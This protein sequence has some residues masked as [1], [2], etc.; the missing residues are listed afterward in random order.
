MQNPFLSIGM[1]IRF[2]MVAYFDEN[3]PQSGV[4]S[5]QGSSAVIETYS[6]FNSKRAQQLPGA[7]FDCGF[8]FQ[9]NLT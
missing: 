8:A 2:T 6:M 5:M 4:G 1:Y 3:M 9:F 7:G